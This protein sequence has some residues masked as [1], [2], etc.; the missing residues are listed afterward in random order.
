MSIR[1][2]EICFSYPRSSL[3]LDR[4]SCDIESGKLTAIVGPN[5]GGKSTLVRLLAGLRT[6]N[7]GKITIEDQ[8]VRSL[9][10]KARAKNI[11]FIEQ[12]PSLAFDFPA[13]TIIEF[14]N[15]AGSASPAYIEDAI[16]RFDLS[17]IISKSFGHL[18]VGQ[19]Q[20]VSIARAW[21]Q[22]AGNPS[23]FL[24]ADE[25]CS[26]CNEGPSRSTVRQRGGILMG[27]Q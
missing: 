2:H 1:A 18:S 9:S 13:R 25:P 20:R 6:P 10:P 19:Q 12:R 7:S 15:Y 8:E 3:V 24:L 5:G 23:G 21:V 27:S 14:G 17:S 16:Q 22:I 4:V 26:A 11:A